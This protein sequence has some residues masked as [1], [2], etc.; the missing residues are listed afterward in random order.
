M[1]YRLNRQTD[2]QRKY[3]FKVSTTVKD[4]NDITIDLTKGK[5]YFAE[6]AFTN[7]TLFRNCLWQI[8]SKL[9]NQK[10]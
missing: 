5:N 7:L 6:F 2:F 9:I 1:L 4:I 3:F 10:P 8:V